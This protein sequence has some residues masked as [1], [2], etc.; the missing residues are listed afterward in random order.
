[1]APEAGRAVQGLRS[2][3]SQVG[4]AY[5][6]SERDLDLRARSLAISSEE[7]MQVNQRLSGEVAAQ[8]RAVRTLRETVDR[9]TTEP[10]SVPPPSQSAELLDERNDLEAVS[11]RVAHLV[12][13]SE[14]TQ[15]ELQRSEARFRSLTQ[16]SSDWYWEQDAQLRYTLMSP[17]VIASSGIDPEQW[18]G[19][20]RWELTSINA[21]DT[22]WSAHRADLDAQRPFRDFVL[23]YINC[24]DEL[25]Y[26][27][28]SGEPVF[29]DN[30]RFCGYRGVGRDIT[31]HVRSREALKAAKQLAEDASKAKSE[32]L[33]N[34]SHEIRTPMNGVLGMTELLLGTALEEKQRRYTM[35]V[36]KSAESLLDIINAVLD[37]S[38]IEAGKM[39]LDSVDFDLPELVEDVAEM[40]VGSSK[41]KNIALL[42]RIDDRVPAAVRGDPGRLR[43]VL[44]NLVGNAVKFTARGEVVVEVC[45]LTAPAVPD[46]SCELEFSVRD[47]GV[48]ITPQDIKRLFTAFT[49]ADGSNSRRYGGTGLGLAISRQLIS[50]MGGTIAV[51]STPGQGSRFRFTIQLSTA[52]TAMSTRRS[53]GAA[54][55]A[56]LSRP[57]R[58]DELEP[59]TVDA[60]RR[61]DPTA[62]SVTE[63]S[64]KDRPGK[65]VLLVDDNHINQEVG[66]AMLT[67]LGHEVDIAN[68]GAQAVAMVE[69][70]CYDVIFM[71]CQM[72][73]MDG[74]EATAAIR[75]H[76][77]ASAADTRTPIIALTANAIRGDRERCIAAGMDDYLAKPFKREQLL[78]V[79]EPW[80][81]A[82][83]GSPQPAVHGT[84]PV[85]AVA[86]D[87]G[88]LMQ[89]LCIGGRTKTALVIKVIT[90]FL[91]DT[92]TLLDAIRNGLISGNNA[93]VERAAHTIKSS[94]NTV[95]ALALSQLAACAEDHAREGRLNE[96]SNLAHKI[97]HGIELASRQLVTIRD[98]LLCNEVTADAT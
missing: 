7:L 42:C 64:T 5:V 56:D 6:Q 69:R 85:V 22:V 21:A 92:P 59:T 93:Q 94:A 50:L 31:D 97:S 30:Q 43:Q 34:M 61:V 98:E 16:L 78:A 12:A 91:D 95:A 17:G 60:C 45:R 8:R 3:L 72:P 47:T 53:R 35:N 48:G 33:A 1:M 58:R 73:E 88:A 55:A 32:F 65:R 41:D 24:H 2:F 71:D 26:L 87:R 36:R 81:S 86:V 54:L 37:F 19:K 23:P 51:E 15:L 80:A 63:Q 39:E 68:D 84:T 20:K 66:V 13:A 46:D 44:I 74:F 49:Q 57:M 27:S 77:A 89:S 40:L 75:A 70:T 14:E 62:H 11:A 28:T 29:D 38:K 4:D 9:L 76:E 52:Q 10:R 82:K 96:V 67:E 18:I 79:L 25:R 90:L 83:A